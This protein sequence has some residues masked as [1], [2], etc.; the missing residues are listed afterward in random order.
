MDG[1]VITSFLTDYGWQIA[2]LALSGILVV[3]CLKCLRAFNWIKVYV[4]NE[5]GTKT[6]DE[7]KSKHLRKFVY[8]IL[9]CVIAV[10]VCSIYIYFMRGGFS[11]ANYWA[12]LAISTIAYSTTIYAVYENLGIRSLWQIILNGIKTGVVSLVSNVLKGKTSKKDTQAAIDAAGNATAEAIV[13]QAAGA[14]D[15]ISLEDTT[16]STK[17]S[18]NTIEDEFTPGISD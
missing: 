11:N 9:N 3:G 8:Y 18:V 12:V 10:A 2:L 17:K 5:D 7:L 6:E 13:N 1:V 16:V 15:E 4:K 14:L